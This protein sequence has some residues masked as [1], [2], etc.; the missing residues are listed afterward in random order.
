MISDTD[1]I[2]IIRAFNRTY[3]QRMGLLAR[4]YLGSGLTVTEMRVLYDLCEDGPAA[5]RDLATRLDVDE[6][7]ISRI[8]DGFVRNGWVTK[9]TPMDDAR[10]RIAVATAKGRKALEPLQDGSRKDIRRRL[11]RSDPAAVAERLAGVLAV[12]EPVDALEVSLRDLGPGDAGWL[13]GRHGELYT[14]DEGYDATFEALVAEILADFIRNRD[15]DEDRAW[16]AE[17][18]GRRLGS[19][20]CV[21]SGEAG[22]AKLRLFLVEPEARGMGLGQRLLDECIAFARARGNRVLRLW[23]HESHAAACRIYARNGFRMVGSEARHSF[24]ADVVDQTWELA[25]GAD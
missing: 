3:T 25:L 14:R 13:T 6:G 23:T 10:R 18:R 16:I 7:Y 24:G 1:P 2:E 8:V 15:P 17:W 21:R 5:V 22:V 11:G 12:L 19:I 20:F 9:N 4:N